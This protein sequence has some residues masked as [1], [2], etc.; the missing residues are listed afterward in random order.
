MT[1]SSSFN[2]CRKNI[3]TILVTHYYY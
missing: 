1:A 2:I 3:S